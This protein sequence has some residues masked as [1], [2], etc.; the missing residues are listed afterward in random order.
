MARTVEARDPARP[1]IAALEMHE[2]IAFDAHV[3]EALCDAHGTF[4]EE[5]IAGALFR[6]EERLLLASWQAEN[7]EQSGLRR[8]CEELRRLG[9]EIGMTT[10]V[11]ATDAVLEGLARVRTD[12]AD[13]ALAACTAR[14]IR[15][16]RPG[17]LTRARENGIDLNTG[18]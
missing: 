11:Q 7:D 8:T 12:G 5:V 6:I 15:M 18:C 16:G 1:T 14:L 3:L 17:T 13:P 4:A 9:R 10:L 2:D